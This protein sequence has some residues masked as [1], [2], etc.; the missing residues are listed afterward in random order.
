[1]RGGNGTTRG[2]TAVEF[3]MIF[4][5]LVVLVLGLLEAGNMLSDWLTVR[6]AAETGARFASTGQGD[7]EGVRLA[8]IR[9][10]VGRVMSRL[11]GGAGEVQVV[12]WPT[13]AASGAG[14]END[15]G[16]PCGLVEVR[17]DYA[18]QP[19]TPFLEA[20]VG[21]S[22]LLTGSDRKVNEPWQRCE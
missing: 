20:V 13:T 12:S 5:L 19:L 18:Y 4:P 11:P 21:E 9:A 3:A 14:S 16:C 6:K 8:L 7:E 10:E 15:A 22:L 17:V 2:M 1:M